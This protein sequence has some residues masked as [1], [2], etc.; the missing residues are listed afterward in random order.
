MNTKKESLKSA[1]HT[2]LNDVIERAYKHMIN[3]PQENDALNRLAN[4]ASET[5]HELLDKIDTLNP[6]TI[7]PKELDKT[8]HL[9]S[10]ELD[11]KSL[12]Y[13]SKLQ[14]LQ[15]QAIRKREGLF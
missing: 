3:Y 9:L 10:Q 7:V 6:E 2:M 12:E 14:E 15:R 11:S 1:V 13:L 4:Q 5:M 8:L